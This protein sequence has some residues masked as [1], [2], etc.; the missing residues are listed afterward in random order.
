MSTLKHLNINGVSYDIGAPTTTWYGTSSTGSSTGAKIVTCSDF[1]LIKGAIITI[2]FSNANTADEITLNINSTGAKGV[3]AGAI[4]VNSSN[5]LKWSAETLVTFM[6]NGSDSFIY[7]FSQVAT[8]QAPPDGAG[9]YYGSSASSESSSSKTASVT[10]FRLLKGT[11]V[12]ITFTYA[13]TYVSG[14]LTLNVASTGAKTI[15]VNTATSSSNTLLWEAGETLTFIYSG[16]YWY[17]LSKSKNLHVGY[18]STE[19]DAPIMSLST[20]GRVTISDSNIT[21][22]SS[23]DP[24]T[25][26]AGEIVTFTSGDVADQSAVG[27]WSLVSPVQSGDTHNTLLNKISNMF[28]NLRYLHNRTKVVQ[29]TDITL[30]LG[31]VSSTKTI[32]KQNGI[33]YINGGFGENTSGVFSSATGLDVIGTMPQGYR[34]LVAQYFTISA[35]DNGGWASANYYSGVLSITQAGQISIAFKAANIQSCRYVHL[36][37]CYP[38]IDSDT[39]NMPEQVEQA[40]P[41]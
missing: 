9:N 13:N 19:L 41:N 29:Q 22:S 26:T 7:L 30:S 20:A 23:A 28:K 10:N 38:C 16:S 11:I 40:D 1:E 3:Q 36:N 17:F 5:P 32:Y 33:V 21:D 14:A 8:G 25:D 15:Y 35:R 34:P 39:V 31:T 2:F 24:A 12:T 27:P 4:A 18:D 37:A 6:Y